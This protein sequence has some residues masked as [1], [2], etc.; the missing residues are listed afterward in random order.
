MKFQTLFEVSNTRQWSFHASSRSFNLLGVPQVF[1]CAWDVFWYT[2]QK[3]IGMWAY[4]L[5]PGQTLFSEVQKVYEISYTRY[6]ECVSRQIK[7]SPQ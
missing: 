1:C 3:T 2:L 4:G 6:H 7:N 5:T